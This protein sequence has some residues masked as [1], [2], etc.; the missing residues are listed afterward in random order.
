MPNRLNSCFSRWILMCAL[1]VGTALPATD[2]L[3]QTPDDAYAQMSQ[4][5]PPG[6][7][8]NPIC[9]RLEGQLASIDRGGGSGDSIRDEQIRRY[10]EAA[11]RQQAELDR[12][13]AQ[14]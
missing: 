3:A 12:V 8:S 11:S 13:I 1:L 14:G 6:A 9:I 4:D 2:A 5:A 10:Q 7:P